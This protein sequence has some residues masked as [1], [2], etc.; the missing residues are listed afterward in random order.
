MHLPTIARASTIISVKASMIIME[1]IM[2]T[3]IK[4]ATTAMVD[5]SNKH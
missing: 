3:A 5:S 4:A 1:K 2:D